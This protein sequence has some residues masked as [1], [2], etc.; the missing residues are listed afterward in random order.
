MTKAGLWIAQIHAIPRCGR[1]Q[2]S[3]E[4]RIQIAAESGY[5]YAKVGT[6]SGVQGGVGGNCAALVEKC[7]SVFLVLPHYVG[8][9]AGYIQVV[10]L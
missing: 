10:Q 6:Q 8:T 1:V 7:F 4:A 2:F 5:G 9:S 3:A